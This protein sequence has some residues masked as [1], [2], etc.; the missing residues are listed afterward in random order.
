MNYK[1]ILKETLASKN[2]PNLILYGHHKINKEEILNE[3]L[4]IKSC[5][6]MTKY[7]INYHSN[8]FFKIFNMNNIKRSKI[9]N[10][11]TLL[12]EIIKCK[13]YYIEQNRILILKNFNHIDY[14][15]YL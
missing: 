11:F 2:T 14:L 9:N 3:Y 7:D 6:E 12:S 10:F 15:S 5:N 1:P 8:Q 4:D 13:N